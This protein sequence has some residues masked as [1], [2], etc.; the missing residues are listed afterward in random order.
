[1]SGVA[2]G[3]GDESPLVVLRD[4][5]RSLSLRVPVGP[6][7]ASSIILQMEGVAPYRPLAHDLL[8]SFF[9]EHRF[10]LESARIYG[11]VPEGGGERFLSRI[12]YRR[13][14]RTWEKEVRPSDA[15]A[16]AIRLG[17]PILAPREFLDRR[18]TRRQSSR[19]KH[20]PLY[21]KV[22]GRPE[23]YGSG[24]AVAEREQA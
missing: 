8:A 22:A 24:A 21:L 3:F 9:Q 16:L 19:E 2:A 15:I 5:R 20:L 4:E 23:T 7:E 10:R 1:M 14:F 11:A 13:G 18:E 17:A 6:Y 12:R